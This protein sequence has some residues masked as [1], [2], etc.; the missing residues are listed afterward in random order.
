MQRC[1]IRPGLAAAFACLVLALSAPG[2]NALGLGKN[3]DGA[4]QPT[5][6]DEFFSGKDEADAIASSRESDPAAPA[7]MHRRNR[8]PGGL[9][10]EARE[11]E[12]GSFN[13]Y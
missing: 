3:K 7:R 6:Y 13:I 4:D 1:P 2:C 8:L 10:P 11:I 9:S 12:R 5:F